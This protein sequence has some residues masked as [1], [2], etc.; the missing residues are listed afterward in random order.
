MQHIQPVTLWIQGTA[1]TANVYDLSI[2]ND[3]LS[4]R[5]SLYYKLGNETVP[6]E[7]E[8]SIIWL[9]DGNL[10]ITGQDY[11]DWDADPSANEWIYNWA[12]NQLNLTII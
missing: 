3:D 6:A 12:A 10:T 8:P 9:Q 11:Q 2:V 5:A 4:T 7:G 1:K